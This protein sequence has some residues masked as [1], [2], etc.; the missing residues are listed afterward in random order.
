MR[1]LVVM[2]TDLMCGT[3]VMCEADFLNCG[4]DL[5]FRVITALK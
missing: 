1:Y 5:I 3:D 4:P 2:D